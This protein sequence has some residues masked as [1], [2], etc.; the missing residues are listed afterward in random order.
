MNRTIKD[1]YE[2]FYA[3]KLDNLDEMD[4]FLERHNL[5]NSHEEK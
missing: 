3:H 4:Q 5:P 1:S 2:Q